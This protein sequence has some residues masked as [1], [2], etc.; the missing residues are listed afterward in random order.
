M[1]LAQ[2]NIG[3]ILAPMG[4]A[5]MKEFEDN[6]DHINA[7]AEKS[8]GFV[9]RL[10]DE[11]NNATSI[12]A[13]DDNYILIN[14]SVWESVDALFNFVYRSQHTDFLKRRPEWFSRLEEMHMAL[15]YIEKSAYPDIPQAVD[16]LEHIRAHGETPYAFSFRKRFSPQDLP[17]G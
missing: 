9:W 11:N 1:Q 7:L 2:I 12:K 5:V 16:R 3:R 8:P 13:F 15:W 10:K 6:L 14:M 17:V 4:S